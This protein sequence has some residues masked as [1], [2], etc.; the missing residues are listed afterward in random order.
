MFFR[1]LANNERQTWQIIRS[2]TYYAA[3]SSSLI[4]RCLTQYRMASWVQIASISSAALDMVLATRFVISRIRL[5]TVTSGF[6]ESTPI[7]QL[8][9]ISDC[10][11]ER[12][13]APVR[14]PEIDMPPL[15]SEVRVVSRAMSGSSLIL[16][17]EISLW[18]LDDEMAVEMGSS[19]VLSNSKSEKIIRM[20]LMTLKYTIGIHER[21]STS[22]EFEA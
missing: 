7:D 20:A 8:G 11:P 3:H 6:F 21:R 10:Q 1:K 16:N 22:N 18:M 5:S 9:L 14:P 2:V 17:D 19:E 15:S 13:Y 4:L 12:T